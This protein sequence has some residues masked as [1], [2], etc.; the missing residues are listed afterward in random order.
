MMKKNLTI[1]FVS[2]LLAASFTANGQIKRFIKNMAPAGQHG[3]AVVNTVPNSPASCSVD[4]IFLTTQAQID[5]FSASYPACTTPQYLIIDGA[6]ASPA[7][8]SLAGLSSITQVINK[9]EIRN[10]SITSLSQLTGLTQIGDT[11]LL[12]RNNLLTSIGLNNLTELGAI[13]FSHLPSLVSVAGLCNNFHKTGLVYIDSTNLSNLTGLHTLDT[14]TTGNGGVTISNC[15]IVNLAALNNLKKMEGYLKLSNNS[16]Q[17][18]IGL[19]N[20][21]SCWGFLFDGMPLLNSVAGL[22]SNL[23]SGNIGTFWFFNTGIATLTGME[24]ITNSSNF[25]ISG[26]NNLTTLNGLQNLSGNIGGGISM[27][28]NALLNDISAL[29]GITSIDDGTIEIAYTDITSLNGLQNITNIG[30]GLWLYGNA[31]LTTLNNLNNNL[32]I[33]NN[34]DSYSGGRDSVRIF[35]NAQLALCSDTSI[36][37]YLS[38][39]GTAEI[40]NNAPGC[41]TIAEIQASCGSWINY[42]DPEDNC[43]TYNAIP[44]NENITR[45]GNVGHY[46]G[47]DGN[48]DPEY[49]QYDTYKIVMPYDGSFKL[50]F[51]AKNDSSCYEGNNPYLTAEI[52]DTYGNYR[53]IST[54]FNW[55]NTDPCNMLQ[56]DS[57]KF[58]G[59][60]GEIFYIQLSGDKISY[61]FYWQA[62]DSTSDEN[63]P[64]NTIA[65]A[66]PISPLETKKGHINFK[67][68]AVN[69]QNDYYKTVLPVSA[70]IEVYFKITNR[71][72]QFPSSGNRFSINWGYTAPFGYFTNGNGLAMPNVDEIIYDTITICG[73]AN[74]TIYFKLTSGQEAYEYEWSYKIKDTLPNDAFEPNNTMATAAPVA[75][76]QVKQSV[77]GYAGKL[78]KDQEDNFVTVFPQTGR[79]K[80]NVQATSGKCDAGYLYLAG[81][82]KQQNYVF[83][84][85]LNGIYN[86]PPQTT[87]SDS[88]YVCGQPADTFYFK[89]LSNAIFNYQFRYVIDTIPVASEDAEPNNSFAT[90]QPVN[91]LDSVNGRLR[92]ITVPAIDDNDYYRTVLPKDGTMKIIIKASAYN[93]GGTGW[94]NFKVYDKRQAGGQ[95]YSK[96]IGISSNLQFGQSVYDTITLCGLAADT[97]YLHFNSSQNIIYSF[98]YQ[99]IDTSINDIEPNNSFATAIAYNENELKK[100]HIGYRSSDYDS[101]DYYR[102]V[103]PKDGTV[104]MIVKITERNC[105][106]G[107]MYMRIY[108]RRQGLGEFFQKYVA[109]TSGLLPGQTLYDTI[110]LCGRAADTLYTRFEH[111]GAFQYEFSYEV[112]DTSANDIESNNSFAT[113]I[114]HNENEV[115]KGHI[116][117]YSNGGADDYDYYKTVLPQDGTVKVMV[118][119]T[120]TSCANGQWFYLR[121]YDR[122]QGSGEFYQKYIANNSNIAAGQTIYDTIY[123]CS[124]AA[125]TMYIRYEASNPFKYEFS[126]QMVD[127]SANDVEPNNS[128]AQATGVGSNQLKK[129]HIKY[130]SNGGA[131]DYDFYK[132]IFTSSDSLKLQM[133]ATNKSCAN[134][135]WLYLRVYNKNFTELFSRYFANISNVGSNQTIYDSIKMYVTAPDTIY[136]RYEASNP[137]QYQFTTNP[138]QPAA[139]FTITGDSAS[140]FSTKIYKATGIVD[141][142]ITYH[143]SL[144]GGGTLSFV[145]SIATVNWNTNGT[146]QLSLYLSNSSGNTPTKTR[147]VIVNNNPPTETPVLNNFARTLSTNNLPSG[148]VCNWY[149]NGV[150]IAGITDSIYYAADSGTYTVKFVR[151]CGTGPVSNSFYF[152][153]PAQVQTISFIHTPNIVM[154]PTAKAKLN[155]TASSGLPVGFQLISGNAI[156]IA[157]T[158]YALGVGQ[159]IVRA[160]QQGDNIYSAAAYKFDTIT[161]VQG[162]QSIVFNQP[163]DTIY[164]SAAIVLNATASSGLAITYTVV[165]GNAYVSGNTVVLTGGGMVTVQANQAGNANYSA[166]ASVQRTFC[167]GLRTLGAISGEPSPCLNTYNYYAQKIPDANYVWTISSG[168]T[169]VPH[170]DTATVTWTTP[171]SHTI[172]VK[173]N[174]ACDATYTNIVSYGIITSNNA[175]VAVSNMLPANGAQNQQ[176]PLTLSWQPGLFTV[177]YDLYVW[178]SA[179]AQPAVPFAANISTVNYTLPQNSL[180]YNKTYKWRVVSKNPCLFTS[181]PIQHFRLIPLPD[182]QVMNVQAPAS[183]FSGQT[184]TFNWTVKNNGPGKTQFGQSWSDAVFLSFDSIPNF[185]IPP[186]TSA[187]AWSQLEFPLRPLLVGTKLNVSALDSGQQYSNSINFTLPVNYSQPLYV[188]VITNYPANSNLPQTTILNDTSRAPQPVIVTLSPTPD[189]RVDT[190]LTTA[191]TFSGNT[192][193]VTY[194]V[195][196][197]GVVTPPGNGWNDKFYISPTANFNPGNAIQLKAPKPNGT[198]YYNATEALANNTLQLNA[199]SSYTKTV[200]V[201]IPNYISGTF[202]IHVITDAGNTVYEGALDNNNTNSRQLQVYL[203]P[204]PQLVINT[205]N[206]LDTAYGTTQPIPIVYNEKNNGFWDNIEK[207]Q[208][209]FIVPTTACSYQTCAYLYN[210]SGNIIG[211]TCTTHNGYNYRDSASWGSSFWQDKIYI[212]TDSSATL[213]ANAILLNTVWHGLPRNGTDYE[214]SAAFS[215]WVYNNACT[216]GAAIPIISSFNTGNIIKPQ[217]D[218][219]VFT[220][221]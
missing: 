216:E 90:A 126:Y 220:I 125:D 82:N 92:F 178:D 48:G 104:K 110:Y 204:T 109:N 67:T 168:G 173:A 161:V 49:D 208:G 135:Q 195:K 111:G 19:T 27:W 115:K 83:T 84:K 7:I 101:Y 181:G 149:K 74:D 137:F 189:L 153:L 26:N 79:L 139:S 6:G 65:T 197:Y 3:S 93:C 21:K 121:F 130:Y 120:N 156:I 71:E 143:W 53:Q 127:T 10:T 99:L 162:P 13:Y 131:D 148:T 207:N 100:G 20:I 12:E 94:V 64:N 17:T 15:P 57:F 157:D 1:V 105:S 68:F 179:A 134:G 124:R 154:S 47:V 215:S 41:N 62:L 59:Y 28:G 129:G 61:S 122:R 184:I 112:I 140:C 80:I 213:P 16:L 145:D 14:L 146:Y 152:P 44:I 108:D 163:A 192:I 177:N 40:Y 81:L 35:E 60:A 98:K 76:N 217:S 142:D 202:F 188:Y 39:G 23:T 85:Y 198:Y 171:G 180:Q 214:S 114:S 144:T 24:G 218:F 158:V 107:Y 150:L 78:A 165:S 55:N 97:F 9:L 211:T 193:L 96:Q 116:K 11:L 187:A 32:V 25:Y 209:H 66:V 36:C 212:S 5:N 174:T 175:P 138:R 45:S 87:F 72:N 37:N 86:I 69:D 210:G 132:F 201:V 106:G 196:N 54:L 2:F 199:D 43:C 151:P 119:V 203:T 38:G 191:S 182:L 33:Q 117:Y 51:S 63:E 176:L 128:F 221:T 141:D 8:T 206:P 169:L 95:Q 22:T 166:A 73:L 194:K 103:L 56:T 31:N 219:P 159:I 172:T 167:V 136:L 18:S 88:V 52:L 30:K 160:Q 34:P 50:F 133:Q 186:Q 147:T 155:A 123:L 190:V 102:T 183:A 164:P 185:S 91:E 70:N 58:R 205:F 29:S 75:I 118:K 89:F 113:A 200:P 46:I 4:T 77:L 42:I 170:N